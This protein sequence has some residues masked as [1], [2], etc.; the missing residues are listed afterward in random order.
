MSIDA[1][2]SDP[3]QCDDPLEDF[4]VEVPKNPLPIPPKP[5]VKKSP[6]E[7]SITA[8]V[9]P[10]YASSGP[11]KPVPAKKLQPHTQIQGQVQGSPVYE[12]LD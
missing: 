3:L 2:K 8:S 12:S 9:N 5:K 11:H 10:S 6:K 4:E 1:K 7:P